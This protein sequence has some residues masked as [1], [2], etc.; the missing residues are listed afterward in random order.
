MPL[1]Y[2]PRIIARDRVEIERVDPVRVEVE[3]VREVDEFCR[4]T[5]DEEMREPVEV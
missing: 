1:Q 5:A 2:I 4:Q 3:A